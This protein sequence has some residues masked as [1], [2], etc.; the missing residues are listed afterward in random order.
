MAQYYA[1]L[2]VSMDQTDITTVDEKGKIV[3][4]VSVKTDPNSIDAALKSAGFSIEQK[5]LESGSWSH[6]LLQELS[7]LKWNIKQTLQS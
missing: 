7:K 1:G 6:W 2:D 4:E 3:F 5:S